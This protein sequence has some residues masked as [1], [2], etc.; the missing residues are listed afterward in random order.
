[1][2]TD[3]GRK[4]N[5]TPSTVEGSK[6]VKI[7]YPGFSMCNMQI[8]K[9][10]AD[11]K[12]GDSC[13]CEIIMKKVGDDIDTYDDNKPRVQVEIHKLGFLSKAG[14]KTKDEYLNMSDEER[15][16]EDKKV[17]EEGEEKPEEEEKE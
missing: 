8:P 15:L 7:S 10:V 5:E 1:M 16:A 9:E 3:M 4:S 11:M 12:V 14:G 2:M 6:K 17:L 13:R